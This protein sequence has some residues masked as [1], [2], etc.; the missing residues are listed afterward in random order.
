MSGENADNMR[1]TPNWA[2]LLILLA[3]SWSCLG[4]GSAGD[5]PELGLVKGTVTM[6]GKPL[7][8]VIINFKP[9]E[10]RPATATTDSQGNYDLIY[11]YGVKGAK[12][13]PNTISFEWPL[14][15][16]GQPIPEKY[17]SK[18]TL[19]EDVEAGSNTF[20]FDLTSK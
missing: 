17:T 6:D 3:I 13:G 16:A 1:S 20:D 19:K 12:I 9:E 7:A 4:C 10:G 5:R 2:S 18:S 14:D 15:A 8:G 11:R